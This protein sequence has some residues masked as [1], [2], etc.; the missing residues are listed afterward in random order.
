M[1]FTRCLYKIMV[2][3]NILVQGKRGEVQNAWNNKMILIPVHHV[4]SKIIEKERTKKK[5]KFF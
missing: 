3:K 5:P 4:I 2:S 1:K